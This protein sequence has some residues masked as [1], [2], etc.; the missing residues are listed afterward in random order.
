MK[1]LL[2]DIQ[3]KSVEKFAAYRGISRVEAVCK[4]IQMTEKHLEELR[5]YRTKI[6]SSIQSQPN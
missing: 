3:M 4:L 6:L 2:N 1:N 5:E